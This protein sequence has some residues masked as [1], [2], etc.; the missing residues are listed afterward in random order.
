MHSELPSQ[1]ICDLQAIVDR[2]FRPRH[3]VIGLRRRSD[4]SL[5][6]GSP[7]I[8]LSSQVNWMLWTSSIM[9]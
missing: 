5:M 8:A 9:R 2:E 3:P 6:G 1:T 7:P 4:R